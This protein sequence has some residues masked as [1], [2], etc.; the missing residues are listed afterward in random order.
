MLFDGYEYGE[1]MGPN[2]HCKPDSEVNN[3]S[4]MEDHKMKLC[5]NCK[6]CGWLGKDKGRTFNEVVA[7]SHTLC[8]KHPKWVSLV[9]GEE[10]ESC[11][12]VGR[13]FEQK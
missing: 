2:Y 1:N 4:T 12:A 9:T 8:C 7:D 3:K 13:N 5:K 11:G 10:E 6:H